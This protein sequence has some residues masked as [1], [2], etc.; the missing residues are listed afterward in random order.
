[1]AQDW[2]LEEVK[3]TVADYLSML[4]AE[5]LGKEYNKAEHRRN[6]RKSLNDRSDAA[7]ERK[8]QNIS[9]I[10]IELG[11][12]YVDG[13]KP[14]GN[15]QQLLYDVVDDRIHKA[16]ELI[17]MVAKHVQ[18]PAELPTVD[19]ILS[20]LVDAPRRT[21]LPNTF[22]KKKTNWRRPASNVNYLAIEAANRS[23]GLAG[24]KFVMRFETARL[25]SERQERLAAQIE[26]IAVTRGDGEGYDILSFETTGVPRLIEVKTTS[27][28]PQ[29]PFFVT[30]NELALSLDREAQYHLYRVYGFR[31]APRL[32]QTRGS[33]DKQFDLTPEQYVARVS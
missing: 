8:H 22:Q 29:T 7:I 24:E 26:H 20:V 14:L 4:G 28:G 30:R 25:I 9:A 5:Q 31:K 27:Y 32:F 3:A 1:M 19:D 17:A 16:P 10:L 11:L 2:T 33:I 21:T 23:L 18:S 6:L 15:Y 12:P 13:Y